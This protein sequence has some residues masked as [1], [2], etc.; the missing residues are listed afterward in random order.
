MYIRLSG[1]T[2][3][4]DTYITLS[5]L[6]YS[7]YVKI[8]PNKSLFNLS[9]VSNDVFLFKIKRKDSPDC[10]FCNKREETIIH[11]FCECEKIIPIWQYLMSIILKK[12]DPGFN[13]ANCDKIV[14]TCTD[15]FVSYLF[16]LLNV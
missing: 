5:L 15:R 16:L 1:R 13:L 4:R 10:T 11:I 9:S 14:G 2:E 6:Y 7:R 12:H 3:V 8:R